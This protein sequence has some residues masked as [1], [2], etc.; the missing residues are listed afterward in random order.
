MLSSPTPVYICSAA[1]ALAAAAGG[2]LAW[3]AASAA[4][5][6]VAA[7]RFANGRW[8]PRA[9]HE[10]PVVAGWIPFLGVGLDFRARGEAFLEEVKREH[11]DVFAL[12]M[13]G[14]RMVFARSP[15][16]LFAVIKDRAHWSFEEIKEEFSEKLGMPTDVP[17]Y[18]AYQADDWRITTKWLLNDAAAMTER[19]IPR[20]MARIQAELAGDS[21]VVNLF[22]FTGR[23]V[24]HGA[25]DALFS[26]KIPIGGDKTDE[27]VKRLMLLDAA[28]PMI[29]AG[30]PDF[31]LP[32]GAPKAR[33]ELYALLS[34]KEITEHWTD[35]IDG[36][37]GVCKDG[38]SAVADNAST[39]IELASPFQAAR[40]LNT[41]KHGLHRRAGNK[42]F[43]MNDTLML[44]ASQVNTAPTLYW[45]VLHILRGKAA[46]TGWYPAVLAEAEAA[47]A[48][49][50][51][52]VSSPTPVLDA[53]ISEAMRLTISVYMF[54]IAVADSGS[55]DGL[56]AVPGTRFSI[57]A[58][59]HLCMNPR[60]SLHVN[61]DLYASDA[62]PVH[63]FDPMRHIL[64]GEKA[65]ARRL[66]PFGA[67]HSMCPGRR[68]A[69]NEVRAAAAALLA[70]WEGEL[71]AGG[72]D[73]ISQAKAGM[74]VMWPERPAEVRFVRRKK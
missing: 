71:L 49:G 12:Y 56:V 8:A 44:F 39:P 74:G 63:A 29:F 5:A 48:G 38:P 55:P 58:G 51:F 40:T 69:A 34:P 4:V 53:C 28:L 68:F 6:W 11:G 41:L 32:K 66:M 9:P 67:G 70:G 1:V 13:G 65:T 36:F 54:R 59:T 15:D 30:M 61:P 22:D 19:Y 50:S 2:P 7:L 73:G 37:P 62:S 33:D 26:S 21:T 47:L 42:T 17:G 45:T 18:R 16:V 23:V 72:G 64:A 14:R 25:A 24:F 10:P 57:P 60:A 27:N 20:A 43:G 52:D 35:T 3:A 46:G 31:L